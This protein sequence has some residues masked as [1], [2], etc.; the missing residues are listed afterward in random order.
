MMTGFW[1]GFGVGIYVYSLVQLAAVLV[2]MY[3]RRRR[4]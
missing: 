2:G 4:R 3:L 1:W